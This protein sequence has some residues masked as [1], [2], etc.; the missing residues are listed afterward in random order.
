MSAMA[1]KANFIANGTSLFRSTLAGGNCSHPKVRENRWKEKKKKRRKNTGLEAQQPQSQ[2]RSRLV[3]NSPVPLPPAS[4]ARE[5]NG[6][7]HTHTEQVRRKVVKLNTMH[8]FA[9]LFILDCEHQ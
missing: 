9:C 3:H 5:K 4:S 7:T 6:Y 1:F 8:L 2:I